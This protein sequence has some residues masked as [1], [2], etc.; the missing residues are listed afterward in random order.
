M[1]DIFLDTA[2]IKEIDKFL[3]WGIGT[4][5]TTNQKIFLKE[6]GCNFEER[7]K[8]IL[9]RVYPLPVS[10][11]GPNNYDDLV[12]T[13]KEYSGWS[14]KNY[15]I[16][17]NI[18]IKVPMLGNGE[19]LKAVKTLSQ[20]GIKTNVT[21]CMTLNQAFL[22]ASAG[23]TYVSLFYNRMQ[24][25]KLEQIK[26]EDLPDISKEILAKQYACNTIIE[27]MNM[28]RISDFDTELIVGSIRKPSD[29]EEILSCAPDIIT[30]PPGI[31]DEMPFNTKTESTLKE[32]DKAWQEFK[33]YEK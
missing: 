19:G 5:V 33:K 3:S 7:A 24:D 13:A 14:D 10:L 29:I 15:S 25:W 21:A 26:D 6:K 23:A 1:T 28:L 4:G 2:S 12:E 27:T 30:I 20:I 17:N 16:Y 8:K 22:A 32:F 18:V 11:E 31:L 9:E